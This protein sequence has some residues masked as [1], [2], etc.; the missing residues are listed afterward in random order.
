MHIPGLLAIQAAMADKSWTFEQPPRPYKKIGEIPQGFLKPTLEVKLEP[1]LLALHVDGEKNPT[2]IRVENGGSRVH[3]GVWR[4][5]EGRLLTTYPQNHVR[6]LAATTKH[7]AMWEVAIIFQHEEFFLTAQQT[8]NIPLDQQDAG[9][10]LYAESTRLQTWP[11]M[12]EFLEE[13]LDHKLLI[14]PKKE[15]EGIRPGHVIWYNFAQG[16][17]LI[18]TRKG[19]ARVH[20]SQIAQRDQGFRYL[21]A[22]EPVIYQIIPMTQKPGPQRTTLRW[23]AV[24]VRPL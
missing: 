23:Q 8:L 2:K 9:G 6:L 18:Q 14:M 16:M 24:N 19:E 15:D 13:D 1:H 7:I 20:W 22:G 11:Q 12:V 5:K 10:V 4:N 3:I 17:G 21:V